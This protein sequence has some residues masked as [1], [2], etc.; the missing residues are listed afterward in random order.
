MASDT[1]TYT[2]GNSEALLADIKNAGTP[3][4]EKNVFIFVHRYTV[5]TDYTAGN[6]LII[7]IPGA[8][9]ILYANVKEVL[10]ATNTNLNAVESDYATG[11]GKTL[12]TAASNGSSLAVEV[13][14]VA[15]V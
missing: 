7:N 6:N 1:K 8:Q 15:R 3:Y 11:V 5:T 9:E 14:I 12:T 2:I 13:F 10:A 4:F